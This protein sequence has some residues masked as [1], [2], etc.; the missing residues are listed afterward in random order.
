MDSINEESSLPFLAAVILLLPSAGQ[1]AVAAACNHTSDPADLLALARQTANTNY[2]QALL[3]FNQ[4]A[5][6]TPTQPGP[7]SDSLQ[8]AASA[9]HGAV[10]PMSPGPEKVYDNGGICT[11]PLS[12]PEDDAE[13]VVEKPKTGFQ[14]DNDD[15]G[16]QTVNNLVPPDR[17]KKA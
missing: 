3:F 10:V 5:P 16:T 4:S 1:T 14:T 7:A 6:S 17:F 15:I 11:S 13:V 8:G 12:Y 2:Q 9:A